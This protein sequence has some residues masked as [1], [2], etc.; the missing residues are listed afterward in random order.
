MPVKYTSWDP[1]EKTTGRTHWDENAKVVDTEDLT[2]E[3]FDKDLEAT[4]DTVE[5]FIVEAYTPYG[6]I[7][8][9]GNRMLTSQRI[10]DIKGYARRKGIKV[11]EVPANCKIVAAAWAQ[12]KLPRDI[13][14]KI[15]HIPDFMAS[16]LV[17]YWYLCK[18]GLIP[19]KVLERKKNG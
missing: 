2:E 9:T 6:H 5:L 11:V 1:G 4:P 17:G 13:K 12:V 10:G 16:Y 8:H 18:E 3:E 7:N 15:K 19:L 14:G